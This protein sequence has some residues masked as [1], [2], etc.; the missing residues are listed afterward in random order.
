MS[1]LSDYAEANGIT[2]EEAAQEL[3]NDGGDGIDPK[4]ELAKLN[5]MSAKEV[6]QRN[7]KEKAAWEASKAAKQKSNKEED[8]YKGNAEYVRLNKGLQQLNKEYA[9][10]TAREKDPSKRAVGETDDRI[11]A[12]KIEVL[13]QMDKVQSDMNVIKPTFKNY[14]A[15]TDTSVPPSTDK[16]LWNARTA[17]DTKGNSAPPTNAPDAPKGQAALTPNTGSKSVAKPKTQAELDWQKEKEAILKEDTTLQPKNY[18]PLIPQTNTTLGQ[19]GQLRGANPNGT[20]SIT[21]PNSVA[22]NNPSTPK[23]GIDFGNGLSAALNYGLPA[24]QAG[25]GYSQL[26]KQGPRPVDAIDPTFS[27]ALNK[28]KLNVTQ[29]EQQA[30]Y[31]FT[32]EQLAQSRM[33]NNNLY[34]SDSY[35]ALKLGLGPAGSLNAQRGAAND[36]FGRALQ[37]QVQDKNLQL[38]KQQMAWGLQDASNNLATQKAEMHRRLFQDDLTGWKERQL[39]GGNLLNTGL[40]N[41]LAANRLNQFKNQYDQLNNQG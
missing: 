4:A 26:Q 24:L 16:P 3:M 22:V 9:D 7:A 34:A 36:M 14:T 5:A 19:T 40:T 21:D 31:G 25:I 37:T 35:N 6:S 8:I 32:P 2:L 41:A 38:Q 28:T 11:R 13:R 39:S 10:I 33:Q 18:N 20:P 15:N 23:K 1:A 12:R 29:A 30:K 17:Q 27:Q